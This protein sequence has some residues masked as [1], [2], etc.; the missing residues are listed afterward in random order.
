MLAEGVK[1][2]T[3]GPTEKLGLTKREISATNADSS[4]RKTHHLRDDG[5]IRTQGIQINGVGCQAIIVDLPLYEDA[6]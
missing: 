2:L 1:V 3:E 4:R 5:N 6:P